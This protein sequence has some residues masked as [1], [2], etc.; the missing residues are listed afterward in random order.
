VKYYF[1]EESGMIQRKGEITPPEK[2]KTIMQ[3][4]K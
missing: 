4:K 3:R 1:E 2:G